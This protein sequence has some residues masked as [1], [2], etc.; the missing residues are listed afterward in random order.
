MRPSIANFKKQSSFQNFEFCQRYYNTTMNCDR[1]SR[2][3]QEQSTRV[4][5]ALETETVLVPAREDMPDDEAQHIWY[6]RKE[7]AKISLRNICI[8]K[9]LKAYLNLVSQANGYKA[10][11]FPCILEDV[12]ERL[13][14]GHCTRGIEHV[15]DTSLV[16]SSIASVIF[17]AINVWSILSYLRC[18][19]MI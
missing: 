14:S 9:K 8:A 1:S 5:F 6:S 7:L 15:C 16:R 19:C 18:L 12:E 11:A 2:R 13:L 17:F 10:T 4:R 3:S